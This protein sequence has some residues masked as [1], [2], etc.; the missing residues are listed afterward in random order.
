M[1]RDPNRAFEWIATHD[2]A[3]VNEFL[4]AIVAIGAGFAVFSLRRWNDLSRQIAEYKRL[5][6]ELSAL[7]R[8]AAIMGET[9]D[10][11]QSCLSTDEAYTIIV[12]HFELQFPAMSG[13]I[14]TLTRAR[15]MAE[16]AASWG[17]PAIVQNLFPIGDC[18]ALRR[19]RVNISLGSDPKLACSHIGSTIPAYAMCIPMMAQGR[20]ERN[21]VSGYRTRP[22][23]RQKP[24][25]LQTGS[26]G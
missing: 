22:G 25:R 18:W 20:D 3:Q 14:F 15:D 10:L 23:A 11:L 26:N 2:E 13:A 8:D 1:L 4:A 21:S 24:S 17:R 5:Q 12:R 19:G 16:L 7:N 9:D 6:T